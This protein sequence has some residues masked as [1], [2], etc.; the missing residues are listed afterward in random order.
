MQ[1]NN[2]KPEDTLGLIGTILLIGFGT[3]LIL[4]FLL[5]VPK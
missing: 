1:S 4:A 2:S 3:L 5:S